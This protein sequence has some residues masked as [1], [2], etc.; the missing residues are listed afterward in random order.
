MHSVANKLAQYG[1]GGDDTLVHMN[2]AEVAG[3]NAL[4]H[5]VNNRPLSKNPVT[6][7]AEAMDLTDILA[8]LGIGIAA[9]LTGGAAA[10]AAPAL[11]GVTAGGAGAMGIGALA[12]AATGAGLN[13]GKAAIKGDQDIGMAAAFGAGSGA[14]GGLGGAA[15]AGNAAVVEGTGNVAAQNISN[16]AKD[17]ITPG[18]TDSAT[19][20]LGNLAP[21]ATQTNLLGDASKLI[22]PD[23]ATST[24]PPVDG[25][26]FSGLPADLAKSDQILANTGKLTGAAPVNFTNAPADLAKASEIPTIEKDPLTG[27]SMSYN[28]LDTNHTGLPYTN[29]T[30]ANPNPSFGDAMSQSF[31]G[32]KNTVMNPGQHQGLLTAQLGMAGLEDSYKQQG[33]TEQAGA[34][35]AADIVGQYRKAGIMPNELPKGLT[36]IAN[37][38]KSFAAGGTIRDVQ[39]LGAIPSGYINQQ[40]MSNFYPQSMMPQ[41]QP[42]QS[43]QPIRH[44]VIGYAKGGELD[45]AKDDYK[46]LLEGYPNASKF[47]D[48]LRQ[49]ADAAVPTQEQMTDPN[50]LLSN[51]AGGASALSTKI[52]QSTVNAYKLFRTKANDPDTLYPLFVNADKPVPM[53]GLQPKRVRQRL[54]TRIKLNHCLGL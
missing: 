8:G 38:R 4:N 7:M 19:Q 23:F 12:G 20:G 24:V 32:L 1:R 15:G 33:L 27:E 54:R 44:E 5:L 31:T 28:A 53:N 14:L 52:P 6:G 2:Q 29:P 35:Q 9:A 17:A 51:V 13:A 37:K 10:A 47:F 41:A 42:L 40:P 39:G 45:K 46:Q 16:V 36:D 26:G 22:T 3:L 43:T 34:K 30:L 48:A 18:L 50:Y 25:A 21:T 49:S 11:L